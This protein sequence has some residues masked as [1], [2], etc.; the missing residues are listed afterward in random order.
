MLKAADIV[1]QQ[2]NCLVVDVGPSM[3]VLYCDTASYQSHSLRFMRDEAGRWK[4]LRLLPTPLE[5][6]GLSIYGTIR[7]IH[8]RVP[9]AT[10]RGKMIR[11]V[12]TRYGITLDEK[13]ILVV[14]NGVVRLT[15]GKGEIKE[16]HYGIALRTSKGFRPLD[17][18]ELT[19]DDAHH[20]LIPMTSVMAMLDKQ[21]G[22]LV[23]PLA[24]QTHS[25][26]GKT[27]NEVL[28]INWRN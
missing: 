20:L 26:F 1:R 6:F 18:E 10:Y 23:D 15:N 7:P 3:P 19:F 25:A 22:R 12:Y 5:N 4:N 13:W 11:E 17:V 16:D 28:V 21:I 9:M 14:R 8:R 2:E 27:K 24:W